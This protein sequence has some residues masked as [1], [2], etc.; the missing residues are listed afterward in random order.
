MV[1]KYV[2]SRDPPQGN[3]ATPAMQAHYPD[4]LPGQLRTLSIQVLAMILEYHTACVING[5]ETT[6]PIP[7]QEIEK[8]LLPL[9]TY[10]RPSGSD[11]TDVWVGDHKARSLRVAVWL[12]RLDMSLS[13]VDDASRSLIPCEVLFLPPVVPYLGTCLLYTSD[14]ADE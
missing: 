10:T 8:R 11:V 3:V 9:E 13:R 5:S 2:A 4:L 14:A 7:S 6:S 12:H 1:Y